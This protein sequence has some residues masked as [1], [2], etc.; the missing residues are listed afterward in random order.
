MVDVSLTGYCI[1]KSIWSQTEVSSIR[2][3]RELGRY[4]MGGEKKKNVATLFALGGFALGDDGNLL[5]NS[6]GEFVSVPADIRDQVEALKFEENPYSLKFLPS[7]L[8]AQIG[9]R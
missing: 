6:E 1:G 8:Q 3:M 4:K 2:R 9:K 7:F 5:R